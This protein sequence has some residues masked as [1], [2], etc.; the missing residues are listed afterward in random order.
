MRYTFQVVPGHVLRISL[1]RSQ[2]TDF[3]I[4]AAI[5]YSELALSHRILGSSSSLYKV[6][7]HNVLEYGVLLYILCFSLHFP[8][9]E[10]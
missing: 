9:D 6:G 4:T 8:I 10:N 5:Y 2:R 3:S 7:V 1:G